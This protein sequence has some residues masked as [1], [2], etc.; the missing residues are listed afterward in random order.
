MRGDAKAIKTIESFENQIKELAFENETL[1]K[2]FAESARLIKDF[3]EKEILMRERNLAIIEEEE[4]LNKKLEDRVAKMSEESDKLKGEQNRMI[5][6]RAAY[7]AD[8]RALTERIQELESVLRQRDFDKQELEAKLNL[9][10]QSAGQYRNEINFWNGKCSTLRRDVEY[11]ER[12]LQRYKDENTK[13]I[14]ECDYLRV[15]AENLEREVNLLRRQVSGLQEDN[16]RINRMYQV[17]ERE[18]VFNAN[19][20]L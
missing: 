20:K 11:Q 8:K 6:V 13:L 3:Q 14:N 9:L 18:S 2:D 15:K 10:E 19:G 16:D 1:R 7:N 12:H 5:Q 17:V 4:T